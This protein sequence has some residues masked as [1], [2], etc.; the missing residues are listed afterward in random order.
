MDRCEFICICDE[1]ERCNAHLCLYVVYM[2]L[3]DGGTFIIHKL[4]H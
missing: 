4:Y 1:G 3:M 2:P